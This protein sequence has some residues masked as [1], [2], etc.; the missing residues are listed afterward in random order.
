MPIV[1]RWNGCV[2]GYSE[3][4]CKYVARVCVVFEKVVDGFPNECG[5]SDASCRRCP[6]DSLALF[7]GEID[8]RSRRGHTSIIYIAFVPDKRETDHAAIE[9]AI[10][11]NPTKVTLCGQ[12]RR[13][14]TR[15]QV[16][17]CRTLHPLQTARE[18]RSSS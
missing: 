3:R 9:F 17:L 12:L 4:A 18:M 14:S 10:H 7:L 6:I 13:V 5:H 16:H 8:L 15:H 11:T 2:R 1:P